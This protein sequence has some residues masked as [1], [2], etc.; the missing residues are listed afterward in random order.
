MCKFTW[1]KYDSL[2]HNN[3]TNTKQ[4]NLN[5]WTQPG[6]SKKIGQLTCPRRRSRTY[7]PMVV[8]LPLEPGENS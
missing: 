3:Q 4:T 6:I 7:K 8:F 2:K 5:K 1:P